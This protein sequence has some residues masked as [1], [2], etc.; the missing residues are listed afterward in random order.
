MLKEAIKNR[1]KEKGLNHETHVLESRDLDKE[2]Q[3]VQYRKRE[4]LPSVEAMPGLDV[5]PL[6]DLVDLPE[7]LPHILRPV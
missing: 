1:L 2:A 4:P 3:K 7:D 5:D 6:A